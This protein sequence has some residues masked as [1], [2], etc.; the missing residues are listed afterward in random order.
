MDKTVGILLATYN[1]EKFVG[2]LLES[3]REQ[4]WSNWKLFV[5]DD[6]S[7]DGTLNIIREF[8]RKDERIEIIS[9]KK[10]FGCAKKNFSFLMEFV[11]K[12]TDLDI[13]M[14]ADQDD[15]WVK[16]KIEL[17]LNKL[18]E[19][20]DGGKL[21]ALVYT[22][23]IVV[24]ERLN[25][26]CDSLWKYQKIDPSR[27]KFHHL[28]I[29]NVVTGATAIFNRKL[30]CI[31]PSVPGKA[32]MHDWWMA[33]VASAFGEID[34]IRERTVFY[35]QH[36]LNE[37][38]A[39]DRSWKK[40]IFTAFDTFFHPYKYTTILRKLIE[41][42][43]TFIKLY[44]DRLKEEDLSAATGFIS[45]LKCPKYLRPFHLIRNSFKKSDPIRTLGFYYLSIFI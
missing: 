3:I 25:I 27:N 8:A 16:N 1:G 6:N 29:Q 20:S 37:T 17:S 9:Y 45:I 35:R 24:D 23:L 14:F 18:L 10:R 5:S 38:G 39:V 13:F 28:L 41:Q 36:G 40:M 21:P 32:V 15:V 42:A 44:K 43:E 2:E 12:K 33:L 22:D 26:I 30:L 4:S 34:Y 19:V 7:E 11:Y 31:S